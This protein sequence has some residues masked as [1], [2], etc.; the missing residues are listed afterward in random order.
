MSAIVHDF[1]AT[2][3][4]LREAHAW[5]QERLAEHAGL[6]RTYVGEIERGTAIASIVTVEKLAHA[7]GVS[8]GEL[9]VGG[10]AGMANAVAQPGGTLSR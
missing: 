5:S 4:R 2:V 8:I 6:N 7:L 3:R 1:G 9:L 10:V